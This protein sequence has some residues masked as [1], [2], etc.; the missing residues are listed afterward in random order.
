ML[1][2]NALC[3]VV[4]V[5]VSHQFCQVNDY[6]TLMDS[7]QLVAERYIWGPDQDRDRQLP[8]TAPED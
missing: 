1:G 4:R 6:S 2:I 5:R 7:G 8:K 3:Y